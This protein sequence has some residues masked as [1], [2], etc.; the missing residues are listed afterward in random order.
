[1]NYA[2]QQYGTESASTLRISSTNFADAPPVNITATDVLSKLDH[3]L[4]STRSMLATTTALFATYLNVSADDLLIDDVYDAKA[5]F[6]KFLRGRKYKKNS[7]RSYVNYGRIL[8][9]EARKL[10]W[11]PGAN[12]PAEW[13]P[14]IA[15][16]ATRNCEDLAR[17][18]AR[19]RPRPQQVTIDDVDSWASSQFAEGRA[20]DGLRRR[21]MRF[22]RVLRD[23]D[24][25]EQ[26]PN[27]LVRED[28]YGIAI[29]SFP[30][31]LRKEVKELLKWKQAAFA[32]DR[33]QNEQLRPVS[34]AILQ[35]TISSLYGF[36]V[37]VRGQTHIESM[38]DLFTKPMVGAYVEWRLNERRVS[39]NTIRRRIGGLAAALRHP[40]YVSF[41]LTWVKAFIDSIPLDD[42]SEVRRRKAQKYLDYEIVEAI[43][44]KIRALRPAA[45]L[46][47][48]QQLARV[49]MH[50]LLMTWLP[51]L[52]WRQRNIRECRLGDSTSNLFK[53]KISPLSEIDKPK[54]VVEAEK[55]NPD[56]QFWQFHFRPNENKTSRNI[57]A[58]LPRQLVVPLEEYLEEF[59]PE[60]VKTSDPGT[61]FVDRNGM[62]MTLDQVSFAVA[63][64]TGKHGGKR[65][66]PH[67]FRDIVAYGWL[68]DHPQ[69]FLRLSKLLWHSNINTTIKTYGGRFNESNGVTAM[70]D[71]HDERAAR[72]Q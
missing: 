17:A 72:K 65:A 71:W 10:G 48:R 45:A 41:D 32:I 37:G 22:W 8:I 70:E 42:P 25:T 67:L 12:V 44:G 27:C 3:L 40:A 43:P 9:A 19:K 64:L 33:P 1:M 68:K 28:R 24:S 66:T 29:D 47:G 18:L 30:P 55:N 21:K 4:S 52:P 60:L 23:T 7:V 6:A 46:K 2:I 63:Q 26:T 38:Q 57:H 59:R 51:M 36:A 14:V 39:G 16:A 69:D 53:A 50:E 11:S 35:D 62:G 5:G 58:L 56:E 13:R 49:V 54:W 61:L 34:A 31:S 15:L 20:Y